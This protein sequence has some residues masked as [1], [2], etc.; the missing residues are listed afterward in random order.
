M[1][2][3]LKSFL[4]TWYDFSWVEVA[5]VWRQS[6]RFVPVFHGTGVHFMTFTRI[7]HFNQ[8]R[9]FVR[10]FEGCDTE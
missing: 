7:I 6:Q 3:V 8:P 4:S 10:T 9:V 1:S 2:A 5:V